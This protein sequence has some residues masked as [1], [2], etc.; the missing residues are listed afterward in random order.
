IKT[1]C[2]LEP[3]PPVPTVS[4]LPLLDHFREYNI[5]SWHHKLRVDTNMFDSLVTLIKDN[6]IFYNNSNNLQ[7]PVEIQLA[8]FLFHA[9]HYGN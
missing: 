8:V 4:Q 3:G 5:K 2:V 6:L 7:F 1:T 9:G